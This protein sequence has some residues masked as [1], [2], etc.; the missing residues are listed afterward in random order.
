[1]APLFCPSWGPSPK[2]GDQDAHHGRE[3]TVGR[4]EETRHGAHDPIMGEAPRRTGARALSRCSD[5]GR[6]E[7]KNDTHD[8]S[9]IVCLTD[10]VDGKPFHDRPQLSNVPPSELADWDWSGAESTQSCHG[11]ARLSSIE[12]FRV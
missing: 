4:N 3:Q 12:C 6:I 9:L 1:M 8:F 7:R 2:T 10:S 5:D 11:T